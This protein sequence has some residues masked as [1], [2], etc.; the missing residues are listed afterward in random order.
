MIWQICFDVMTVQIPDNL[1]NR[2][3]SWIPR[4]LEAKYFQGIDNCQQEFNV[5]S[6]TVQ[7]SCVNLSLSLQSVDVPLEIL[8]S[9]L[10][11]YLVPNYTVP[12]GFV[13]EFQLVIVFFCG[14]ILQS[15]I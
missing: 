6:K 9:N 8:V 15:I 13:V 11:N 14:I 12:S 3:I 4:I 2:L 7:N 1:D 5:Y 10:S